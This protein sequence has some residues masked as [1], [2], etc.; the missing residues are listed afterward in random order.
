MAKKALDGSKEQAWFKKQT[1]KV[2][3]KGYVAKGVFFFPPVWPGA[4]QNKDQPGKLD[5]FT[6]YDAALDVYQQTLGIDGDITLPRY[7]SHGRG[8]LA[9]FE[10]NGVGYIGNLLDFFR[11][12]PD[13]REYAAFVRESENPKDEGYL[14]QVRIV[15]KIALQEI[16]GVEAIKVDGYDP[17]PWD[18]F[19]VGQNV[20]LEDLILLFVASEERR[21]AD[22]SKL[23]GHSADKR[24]SMEKT[25]KEL[26][27]GLMIE[28]KRYPILRIWSM[29]E[30][31]LPLKS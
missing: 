15:S 9:Y 2:D 26:V 27:F 5:F 13:M 30:L 18:K 17:I 21:W 28:D 6:H 24:I 8:M 20:N 14:R 22:W 31:A 29:A 25:G 11:L 3:V 16:F 12:D 10:S 4:E 23:S 1:L 19:S 7:L